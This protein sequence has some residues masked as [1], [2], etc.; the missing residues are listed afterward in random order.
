MSG[1]TKM[2]VGLVH[3]KFVHLQIKIV[4]ASRNVVD[5]E[6][7]LWR[8]TLDAT[9]QPILM[10]NDIQAAKEKMLKNCKR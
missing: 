10:V 3:E 8:D 9:S 1:K 4:I 5:P 2:Y 7:A 6:G